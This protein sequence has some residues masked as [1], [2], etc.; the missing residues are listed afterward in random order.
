MSTSTTPHTAR[1]ARERILQTATRLFYEQGINVTGVD[2][3]AAAAEVSKRTLYK[4][5]G[6][7]EGV[8]TAYLQRFDDEHLLARE[9][10]HGAH[11]P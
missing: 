2:E 8:V 1:G 7:K 11:G 10:V 3:L 4:H 9:D 5:F 6:N